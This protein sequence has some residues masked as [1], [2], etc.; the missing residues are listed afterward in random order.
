MNKPQKIKSGHYE[1]RNFSIIKDS[2]PAMCSERMVH[3]GWSISGHKLNNEPSLKDAVH[4]ID[5]Y[6]DHPVKPRFAVVSVPIP[7]AGDY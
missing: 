7:S 5:K 6:I 2:H 1:Y 3:N 4:S